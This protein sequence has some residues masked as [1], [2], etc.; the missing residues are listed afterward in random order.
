MRISPKADLIIHNFETENFCNVQE[1]FW[2]V[3]QDL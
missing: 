3:Q 2:E 1:F